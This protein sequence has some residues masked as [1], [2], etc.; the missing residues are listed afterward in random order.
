MRYFRILVRF[1]L[2]IVAMVLVSQFALAG[3]FG[4]GG[5]FRGRAVQGE[6]MI[7]IQ[8][9]LD[10]T[11]AQKSQIDP[12]VN[13]AMT[14][15]RALKNQQGEQKRAQAMTIVTNAF[16]QINPI[17]T[18]TQREKIVDFFGALQSTI[19]GSMGQR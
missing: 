19:K 13:D 10:L 7:K 1:K 16:E 9:A 3:P 18:P 4:G 17:L 14:R 6:V 2:M 11:E 8:E 15:F 12:I 5:G